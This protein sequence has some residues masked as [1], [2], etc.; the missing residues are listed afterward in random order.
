LFDDQ[1]E[2]Y[3]RRLLGLI[4][5]GNQAEFQYA[6]LQLENQFHWNFDLAL[7]DNCVVST[8]N[9][10]MD[11]PPV[12]ERKVEKIR[13]LLARLSKAGSVLEKRGVVLRHFGVALEGPPGKAWLPAIEKA[14]MSWNHTISVNALYVL[15]DLL[16]DAD[17]MQFNAVPVPFRK[18][19]MDVHFKQKRESKK[20]ETPLSEARLK[21]LWQDLAS[22]DR[23]TGYAATRA[24]VAAPTSAL[25]WLRKNLKEP[26]ADQKIVT[27]LGEAVE[28]ANDA[29]TRRR[30]ADV[31]DWHMRNN[32]DYYRM[33]RAV[34]VLEY[35]PGPQARAFLEELAG[36]ANHL[37]LTHE[38]KAAL[39]RITKWWQWREANPVSTP[40]P[41]SATI[42]AKALPQLTA[43]ANL[44]QRSPDAL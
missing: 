23:A 4:T 9:H 11:L 34:Q 7:W 43:F 10:I 39:G 17:V 25:A 14:A 42:N 40:S 16:E 30:I 44:A 3:L 31:L 22:N 21:E 32:P 33:V 36:G 37:A 18:H 19:A 1:P 29:E 26:A 35:S 28:H 41:G 5:S 24:L 6:I 2:E 38:S 12:I 8:R 13:P 20:V 15:G 27:P